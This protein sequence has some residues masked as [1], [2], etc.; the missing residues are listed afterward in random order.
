MADEGIRSAIKAT[1]QNHW[2]V[3]G[4]EIHICI[5]QTPCDLLEAGYR[6]EVLQDAVSLRQATH[7]HI[8]LQCMQQ[9]DIKSS[10]VEMM[11][12]ALLTHYDQPELKSVLQLIKSLPVMIESDHTNC[13]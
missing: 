1:E 12:F 6:A 2:L 10:R 8:G 5:Y 3:Y 13:P 7:K 9:G 11:F 4:I